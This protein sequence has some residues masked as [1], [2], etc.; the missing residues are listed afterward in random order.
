[1]NLGFGWDLT[2]KAQRAR[3]KSHEIILLKKPLRTLCL[4]GEYPST[5]NAKEPKLERGLG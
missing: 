3:R 1:M 5:I 4:C 2:A